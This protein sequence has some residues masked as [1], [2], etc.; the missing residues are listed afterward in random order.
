MTEFRK[1]YDSMG[2]VLVPAKVYFGAQTMRS[3]HHF[4]IGHDVLPPVMIE[5]LGILKKAAAKT[6]FALKKLPKDKMDLIVAAAD[7][8]IPWM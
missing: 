8:V 7:E 2:E 1:E 4:P 5:S 3:I 6:N